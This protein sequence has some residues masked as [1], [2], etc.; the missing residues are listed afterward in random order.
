M[1]NISA[2]DNIYI[3]QVTG[4]KKIETVTFSLLHAKQMVKQ[5]NCSFLPFLGK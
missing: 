3:A 2:E 5:L 4:Q 1:G